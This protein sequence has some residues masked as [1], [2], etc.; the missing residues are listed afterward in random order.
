MAE[1]APGDRDN[2]QVHLGLPDTLP[3]LSQ[4]YSQ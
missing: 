1:L 3:A 4:P 2:P